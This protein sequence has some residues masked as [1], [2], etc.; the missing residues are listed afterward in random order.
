MKPIYINYDKKA[1]VI[2]NTTSTY[3]TLKSAGIDKSDLFYMDTETNNII[4][5]PP[6]T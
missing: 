2:G 4:P 1:F 6:C 5:I 3:K